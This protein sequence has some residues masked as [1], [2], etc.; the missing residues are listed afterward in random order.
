MILE[1]IAG[2]SSSRMEL[3]ACLK[4]CRCWGSGTEKG[5]ESLDNQ[6]NEVMDADRSWYA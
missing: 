6:H 5:V 4:E 2:L 1:R 3:S